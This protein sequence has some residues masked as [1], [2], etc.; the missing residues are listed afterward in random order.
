MTDRAEGTLTNALPVGAQKQHKPTLRTM[1]QIVLLTAAY[2]AAAKLGLLLTFSHDHVTAVWPP[3]GIA[4]AALM[5]FGV[6]LWPGVLLGAVIANISDGAPLPVAAGIGV[7]N[8][9]AP[10]VA[11]V[12]LRRLGV[13]R[14]LARLRD[15]LLVATVGGLGAMTI[16]AT[17]GTAVLTVAGEP[18]SVEIWRLWWVG[19]AMGVILVAPFLLTI[20]SKPLRSSLLGSWH[21]VILLTS[22]AAVT[23][24]AVQTDSAAGY[25]VIPLAMWTAIR[26]EQEGAAA[27]VLL[28]SAIDLWHAS[29][30]PQPDMPID[31]QLMALQGVN[32]TIALVLLALA[33]MMSER[34]R[35]TEELRRSADDL[36]ERV[37][38]RTEL[39]RES[40]ERLAQAQR[41]AHIG[42]F[43]WDATSDRNEWSDE[44][45]R[46][47]GLDPDLGPPGF[48]EY[49]AFVRE[50]RRDAVAA[51]IRSAIQSGTS[52]D[53]EYP[54]VLG[55]GTRKWVEAFIEILKNA[56]GDLIGLRGTCQDVTAR[57]RAETALR[58]SESRFRA[59]VQSAPDA[60]VV[61]DANGDV[62]LMNEQTTKLL[63]YDAEELIG[64]SV[65]V[66]VP[67]GLAAAHRAERARYVEAPSVRPMGNGRGLSARRKDGSL[68]P[69]DISLSPVETEEGMLVF[70]LLRDAS[71]RRREEETL[72]SALEKERRA[73]ADLRR[74]DEAKAAFLSA[75]SHEL[76]TPLT[77]I[78]GF[79]ELLQ[80][81]SIRSSE[82][83]MTDL[84]R[85]LQFSAVRLGDLLT[86]L[87]DVDRLE[88]GI[89]RP[90]RRRSLLR[91]IV[92]RAIAPLDTAGHPIE[93]SVDDRLV[94]VDP[95]QTERIVENLVTN[96]V[97]Y[98]ARG[99]T[100][101]LTA[102]VQD[103]EVRIV[104]GDEGPGVP[105]DMRA[106]IFEPFVRGDTG[107]FTPGTGLGLALVDRFARLHGGRAWVEDRPGGGSEFHVVL[108]GAAIADAVA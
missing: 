45:Y 50:D 21:A 104:V 41:L 26:L 52:L 79:V 6:R 28:M 70:A 93:V 25:L 2:I 15:V 89:I 64:R 1:G 3:T 95:A 97:K 30:S 77:A 29:V 65:D 74:L 31:Q 107:S 35:A 83:T 75:V 11:T 53:H 49:L 94:D 59:L 69:V 40:E 102:S 20:L 81:E 99:K 105:G 8:A 86:D 82:E 18:R 32:A 10:V 67:E 56:D 51:S 88:R 60:V 66:L 34:R 36:E 72:R 63:G 4:V 96:A 19:D 13:V 85:R 12:V 46:I 7:G 103:D 78:L 90:H 73:A 22:F 101:W 39:L 33:A 106:S 84:V 16:S 80:D 62:V 68:V 37:R 92:G 71:E 14:T 27:A 47:Y 17:F 55:D 98:S 57:Q 5:V 48:E 42:S 54:V 24:F 58:S 76:R 61:V 9:L 44:L 108:P 87:I 23:L 91:D 43:Q 100:V 38:Q